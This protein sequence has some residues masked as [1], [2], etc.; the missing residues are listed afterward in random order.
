MLAGAFLSIAIPLP[1]TLFLS[2]TWVRANGYLFMIDRSRMSQSNEEYALDILRE[3]RVT[4][5][6]P[7]G[8]Y[9]RLI[10]DMPC[11][12]WARVND[13]TIVAEMED[14]M[15]NQMV[16]IIIVD[17]LRIYRIGAQDLG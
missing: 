13:S 11:R 14:H 12:G 15:N 10:S 9:R 16:Y 6:L 1:L 5:E 2:S 4:V 8:G 7:P 3:G 17:S